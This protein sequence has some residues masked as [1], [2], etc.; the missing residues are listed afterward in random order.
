MVAVAGMLLIGLLLVVPTLQ[1]LPVLGSSLR[2]P[3]VVSK[4]RLPT[5]PWNKS[6]V[7]AAVELAHRHKST[8]HVRIIA[9]RGRLR[10]AMADF[11]FPVARFGPDDTEIDFPQRGPGSHYN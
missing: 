5:K 4:L 9:Q 10:E 11:H 8:S 3:P 2:L 6:T 1:E 7:W